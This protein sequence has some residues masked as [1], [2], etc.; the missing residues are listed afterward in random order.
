MTSSTT[1]RNKQDSSPSVVS[2]DT[3]TSKAHV[4]YL[5]VP[6]VLDGGVPDPSWDQYPPH[7]QRLFT[8]LNK[9]VGASRVEGPTMWRSKCPCDIHKNDPHAPLQVH[10]TPN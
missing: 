3:T 5:A 8:A 4:N 7:L 6:V 1:R 10:A 2:S 9:K